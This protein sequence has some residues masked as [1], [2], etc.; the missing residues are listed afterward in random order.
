MPAATAMEGVVRDYVRALNDGNLDAI[1]ALFAADATVEDPVGSSPQRGIDAI[2][3][4]YAKSL[5]LQLG[6]E[7]EGPVRAAQDEVAFA[8]RVTFVARGRRTTIRPIDVF[9]FDAD[10]RIVQMRAYFG[11][12]NI[13]V[14]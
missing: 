3:A 8:F 7:L 9:R 13:E 11:P 1:V 10:G 4:F 14:G 12:S 2:R 5:V 6:V